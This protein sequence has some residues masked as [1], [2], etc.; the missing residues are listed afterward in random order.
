MP[1]GELTAD[2]D[3][4]YDV[5]D[6]K[7]DSDDDE[8]ED[9]EEEEGDEE[10]EDGDALEDT[11]EDTEG[12]ASP[13]THISSESHDFL[14]SE[15]LTLQGVGERMAD[16]LEESG[17]FSIEEIV[18]SSIDEL[19]E[20]PGVGENIARRLLAAAQAHSAFHEE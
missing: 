6:E 15:L 16:Q 7:D 12:T 3:E 18:S 17:F 8:D 1:D 4:K 10:I 19:S 9:D 11:D 13:G 20:V 14:H 5:D 2:D